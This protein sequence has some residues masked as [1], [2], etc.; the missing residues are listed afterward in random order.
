MKL[1]K[2]LRIFIVSSAVGA[3][4][5]AVYPVIA[6]STNLTTSSFKIAIDP[7][8]LVEANDYLDSANNALQAAEMATNEAKK[9]KLFQSALA[10]MSAAADAVN[11][12]AIPSAANVMDDFTDTVKAADTAKTEAEEQDYIESAQ[13]AIEELKAVL[14][15]ETQN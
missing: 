8:A 6:A 2:L 1:K 9:A 7:E 5:L 15:A 13:E 10:A 3:S 12:E 4:L 11:A 14:A